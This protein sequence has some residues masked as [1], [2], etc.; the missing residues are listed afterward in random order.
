MNKLHTHSAGLPVGTRRGRLLGLLLALPFVAACRADVTVDV[1]V[2]DDGAGLVTTELV[3]DEQAA[4]GLLDL[5]D[6]G[7]RLDDLVQSGWTLDPPAATD[8]GSVT[9][10][11]SK[12]F[13]TPQQFEQVM[14]E[15]SGDSG[16]FT[17]FRL[18]RE[19]SFARVD[20]G[21]TGTIAP[22]NFNGFSDVE[23]D[24]LL[25]RTID[26]LAATYGATPADVSVTAVV[27]L[28]GTI[29]AAR[30]SGTADLEAADEESAEGEVRRWETT[31]A[32][33]SVVSVTAYSSTQKVAAL[34]WRGVA[35]VAAALAGLV[36]FGQLLR[37][38][39]PERRRPGAS[40]SR[41]GAGPRQT[42]SRSRQT[43][44]TAGRPGPDKVGSD[45]VGSDKGGS[46]KAGPAKPS[47]TRTAAGNDPEVDRAEP[48][49]AP[50]L[51]A[52]DGMGV[53][54]RE[55]DDIARILVP[56]VRAR[57]STAPLDDIVARARLL[58][59]GRITPAEFWPT[60]GVVGD[61]NQLDDEYLA[62]FQ[63]S[64]GVVGFLRSLRAQGV[65]V[66]CVTNDSAVWANKLRSRHSLEGLIEPW[67]ISGSVGVRKPDAPIY[68]V[69]RRVT[70]LAPH[71]ILIVDDNL[72]NLDAAKVLGFSTAWY[73][74]GA[75]TDSSRGH[76]VL[77]S[78]AVAGA[79]S[80]AGAASVA[81][82]TVTG[83]D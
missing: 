56:F 10:R 19:R 67:V 83:P 35:V 36:L 77:R 68:E 47:Q 18:V 23:L 8:D 11:A 60:V 40:G 25:L 38:L 58:S 61:A 5:S 30:S 15:L 66:A 6:D 3:L 31:L 75:S 71:D 29:D 65:Q 24:A 22:T 14:A 43:K 74:P 33:D 45:K 52:L 76:A 51:V 79:G 34:V 59:L 72:D 81:G 55:G 50:K 46:G 7:L 64:P 63:L 49:L 80:A 26:D 39:R 70:Q 2:E 21:L 37:L 82:E 41:R 78:F 42:S 28:P 9:T 32:E 4:A 12:A 48:T 16:L 13:G 17:D 1:V 73:C 62:N 27:W 44:A 53:L 20:Y 57:G 69:L 54:Y